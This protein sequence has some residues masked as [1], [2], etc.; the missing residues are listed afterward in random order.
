MS[1]KNQYKDALKL[2]KKKCQSAENQYNG[3]L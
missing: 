1:S 3:G 2:L